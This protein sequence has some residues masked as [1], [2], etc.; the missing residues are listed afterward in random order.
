ML[1]SSVM[2]AVFRFVVEWFSGKETFYDTRY[3]NQQLC[4]L[5]Y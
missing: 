1:F 5:Y 4:S 3:I 2:T